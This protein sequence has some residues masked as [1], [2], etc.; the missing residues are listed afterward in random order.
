MITYNSIIDTLTNFVE[1]NARFIIGGIVNIVLI[2]VFFKV[3]DFF[4]R[5][6][7]TKLSKLT[8]PKPEKEN[9]L[10]MLTPV[11]LR[12]LKVIIAVVLVAT[13]LQSCGYNVTSLL[14]GLG[15]TGLAIG[16]A[17]KETLGNFLGSFSIIA[18]KVYRI[19]DYIRFDDKAGYVESLN[20]RS[21]S[22]R[23]VDGFL[24]N[25]PNNILSNTC[26]TNVSH[27]SMYKIDISLKIE[28]SS[29]TETIKQAIRI[30][31][32]IADHDPMVKDG[33]FAF[34]ENIEDTAISLRLLGY[35]KYTNWLDYTKQRSDMI[36]TIL[37]QFHES[38]I[39][40]D[41]PDSRLSFVKSNEEQFI[42]G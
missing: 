37:D 34:I 10:L 32:T 2:Y 4:N 21:T 3:I 36:I 14:A 12:L 25:V 41:I 24:V 38:G 1:Q 22:L 39:E 16:F 35:T 30:L 18:D 7:T 29:S 19:G 31:Q 15:I 8:N 9:P 6:I 11:L 33:A 28:I 20:L 13:F 26:V 27:T 5:K 17:A 40:L 23:T 42:Q